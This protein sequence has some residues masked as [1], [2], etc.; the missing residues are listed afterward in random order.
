M[1]SQPRY[2]YQAI[3]AL[4]LGDTGHFVY[5]DAWSISL[6]GSMLSQERPLYLWANDQF[7]LTEAEID[8]L[9]NKLSTAQGQLMQSLTGLI[10]PVCTA[11]L[12]QGTLLCDGSTHLRVDYPNLYDALDL[13]YI[14]DADSFMVPDLQDR[15]VLA[16]GPLH[17]AATSGGSATATL[18]V[19]QLPA[20]SHT[21]QPHTHT[22]VTAVPT[23]IA[24]GPGVPA[25]SAVPGAGVT[26]TATV[27]VD[28]TG[29]GQPVDLNPPYFA[30]RYVVVAL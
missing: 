29:N 26:G 20:H 10:M 8:D 9:D 24:I 22:E 17:A 23:A 3:N 1:V 25:A 2:S 4:S 13:A 28:P 14:I 6:L 7:P 5:L 12:P 21:T 15:F 11:A 30:L 27:I 16:A 18:T 19:D